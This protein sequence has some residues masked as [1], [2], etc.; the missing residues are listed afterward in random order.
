MQYKDAASLNFHVRR[1]MVT[2]ALLVIII[3]LLA[4]FGT[5]A[6]VST[7]VEE[8]IKRGELCAHFRQEPWPEGESDEVK[9]RREFIVQQINQFCTGL[10][11]AGNNLRQKYRGDPLV[12][13]KLDGIKDGE[14]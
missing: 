9:E 8:F 12:I 4:P 14:H 2:H 6:E 13:E 1:E 11:E 10:H 5:S 3:I 7:D